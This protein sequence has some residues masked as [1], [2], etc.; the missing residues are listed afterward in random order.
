MTQHDTMLQR[1]LLYTGQ[2]KRSV[3]YPGGADGQGL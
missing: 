2:K 1:S 3:I